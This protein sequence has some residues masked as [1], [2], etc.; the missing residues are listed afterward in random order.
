[1]IKWL[2]MGRISKKLVMIAASLI[3]AGAAQAQSLQSLAQTTCNEAVREFTNKWDL[4]ANAFPNVKKSYESHYN[5][6]L[7]KCFLLDT[8]TMTDGDGESTVMLLTD[9][10][11][12]QAPPYAGL[13]KKGGPDLS[14]CVVALLE[15]PQ[16]KE[17]TSEQEWR[18][19][20]KPF[21]E[22]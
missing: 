2:R 16:A 21:M 11:E 7:Q 18:A 17:C 3:L 10:F 22:D 9:L 14:L 4:V 6:R 20:I 8:T 1:L 19:L 15:P 12:K 13:V 5:A